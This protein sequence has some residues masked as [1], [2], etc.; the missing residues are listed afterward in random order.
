MDIIFAA[1]LSFSNTPSTRT[2]AKK[3]PFKMP[4]TSGLAI[5][6]SV[7]RKR[8]AGSSPLALLPTMKTQNTQAAMT[9]RRLV[10]MVLRSVLSRFGE[11]SIQRPMEAEKQ[12]EASVVMMP[13]YGLARDLGR[14]WDEGRF[15]KRVYFWGLDE[16]YRIA[17]A[18]KVSGYAAAVKMI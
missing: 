16:T 7:A 6:E 9:D 18:I 11:R 4:D 17:L 12:M 13:L 10:V 1:P 2:A 15:L 8:R 3:N 14:R 5:G